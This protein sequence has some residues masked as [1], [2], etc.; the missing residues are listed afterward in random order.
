MV[1]LLLI[2]SLLFLK[3]VF[4]SLHLVTALVAARRGDVSHGSLGGDS[5]FTN[6]TRSGLRYRAGTKP[7]PP[8]RIRR[9]DYLDKHN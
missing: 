1:C 5:V 3:H 8:G 9:P 4:M 6:D 7:W 2:A